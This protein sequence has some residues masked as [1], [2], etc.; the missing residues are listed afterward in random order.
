MVV[1]FRLI[2]GFTLIEAIDLT[3]GIIAISALVRYLMNFKKVNP[4]KFDTKGRPTGVL[5]DYG[6]T[7]VIIPMLIVGQLVGGIVKYLLPEPIIIAGQTVCLIFIF[8]STS[9]NLFKMIRI[10]KSPFG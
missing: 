9:I 7:L 6:V 3:Q 5:V 2:F 10:E 1:N 4:I 8:I